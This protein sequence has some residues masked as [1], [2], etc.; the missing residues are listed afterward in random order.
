[1]RDYARL[2]TAILLRRLAFQVNHASK[3]G[4]AEA[5]HDLRVAI[6][7]FGACLRAFSHF[8][9]RH[10]SKR[11]RRRLKEL[12]GLAGAVRN[13]DITLELLRE[14]G[15]PPAAPLALRLGEERRRARA[16]LEHE[17]GRWKARAFSRKWRNSLEL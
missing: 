13:L 12:M 6:R 4:T 5:V 3:S 7:R 2:Q 11:I 8:Y 10:I 17:I 16:H 1:M 14:A 9:P 15:L